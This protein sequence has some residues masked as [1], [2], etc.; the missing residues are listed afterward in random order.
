MHYILTLGND[1]FHAN[2]VSEISCRKAS[3]GH[4]L[5]SKATLE[6]YMELLKLFGVG[7]VDG[8]NQVLQSSLESNEFTE[9]VFQQAEK[10]I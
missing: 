10:S 1:S 3:R 6:P 4:V 5:G 8:R 7:C 9:G 2:Q